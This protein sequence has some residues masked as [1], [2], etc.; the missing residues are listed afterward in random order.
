MSADSSGRNN[1]NTSDGDASE[2]RSGVS[3]RYLCFSLGSEEFAIPLLTVREVIGLPEVKPVPQST[4]Y[5]L[6]IANLRDQF[7]SIIDLRKKLSINPSKIQETSVIIC[8][9]D[10]GAVGVVVDSINRVITAD[11][12]TVS[13]KPE[14]QSQNNTDYIQAVYRDN[15]RLVLMLD[16]SKIISGSD[17]RTQNVKAA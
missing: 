7:I 8:E 16:I 12:G 5:F 9:L 3:D 2:R 1:K 13:N 14:I 4:P 10:S 15:G 17:Y 11:P 6:G